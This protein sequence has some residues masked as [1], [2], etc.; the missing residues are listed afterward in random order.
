[1]NFAVL[2]NR[3][4]ATFWTIHR[5][6]LNDYSHYSSHSLKDQRPPVKEESGKKRWTH[7]R[8]SCPKFLRQT[9]VEW[10]DQSRRHS[11]WAAAFYQKQR[12]AG[13]SH[14]KAIRALAY[15]WGRILW[16]CWQDRQPYDE[17]K[18]LQSLKR[19]AS[20]LAALVS[21]PD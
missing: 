21:F 3:F 5:G 2:D 19:K 16:R 4:A 6:Y 7:W 1:V 17:A 15:K 11:E 12:K 9:F 20:P 14:P 8:W 13:K 10:T 18:Y